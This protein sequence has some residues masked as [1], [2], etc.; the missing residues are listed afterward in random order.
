LLR[1]PDA[2]SLL[3]QQTTEVAKPSEE[4]RGFSNNTCL[5]KKRGL[6]EGKYFVVSG[7]S[8]L[9]AKRK[10]EGSLIF[11]TRRRK[12]YIDFS[13]QKQYFRYGIKIK[14]TEGK[15]VGNL[16]KVKIQWTYGGSETSI[17]DI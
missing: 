1:R 17:F 16:G 13:P 9:T 14:T 4:K 2:R 5:L 8:Y 10:G 6:T 11:R 15:R 12:E 3:S 7:T